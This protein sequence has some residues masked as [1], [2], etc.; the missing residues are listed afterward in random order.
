MEVRE[1]REFLVIDLVELFGD[2]VVPEFR[3][4]GGRL[5]E[6]FSAVNLV[7]LTTAVSASGRPRTYPVRFL[8]WPD[9]L[10][11]LA[12][13]EADWHRDLRTWPHATVEDGHGVHD[14][15]ASFPDGLMRDRLSALSAGQRDVAVICLSRATGSVTPCDTWTRGDEFLCS[16]ERLRY[17]L[18]TLVHAAGRRMA[19][20]GVPPDQDNGLR[21][22]CR[23]FCQDLRE[24]LDVADAALLVELAR[25]SD[26]FATALPE[27]H[28]GRTRLLGLLAALRDSLARPEPVDHSALAELAG[29]LGEQFDLEAARVVPVLNSPHGAAA[30]EVVRQRAR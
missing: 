2:W 11:V 23:R 28:R 17:E 9:S 18:G 14:V 10:I 12:G 6:P 19:V 5:R 30:I 26:A 8:S 24:L 27:I 7:L 3:A 16:R 21:A 13:P 15:V 29:V 22:R 1:T 20:S 4:N 25:H